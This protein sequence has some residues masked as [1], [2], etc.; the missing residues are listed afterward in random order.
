MGVGIWFVISVISPRLT[1][2]MI[3]LFVWPWAIEWVF[4][5]VEVVGIYLYFYTWGKV[6]ARI[7]NRIG[8]IFAFT[9]WW[10]LVIINGIISFMLTPGLWKPSTPEDVWTAFFNPIFFPTTILRTLIS[11]GLAGAFVLL[12]LAVVKN[13]KPH[14]REGLTRLGYRL[15][16]LSGLSL[17]VGVWA[18]LVLPERSKVF[19]WG[20]AAVMFMFMMFGITIFIGLVAVAAVALRRRDFAPTIYEAG[21]VVLFALISY[22]SFEFVREGV[23][24]PYV[25]EK[26]MYSTGVT[27]KEAEAVDNVANVSRLRKEGVLSAAPYA[28]PPG[29]T[30]GELAPLEK[31][32]AVFVAACASCHSLNGYLPLRPYVRGWS[33][34]NLRYLLDNMS[35]LKPMMPPFPGTDDEKAAL[36]IYLKS[37]DKGK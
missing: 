24:K 30:A 6:P 20:G 7:H 32:R 13:V 25:I 21:L 16:L 1:S 11:R 22:G 14:V 10:T 23:R 27:S 28:I 3:H 4:F 5:F 33:D 31:G 19:L 29:K 8:W 18:F 12:L 17:P 37:L 36:V 15:I 35:T 2:A 9:T 34:G 26:F